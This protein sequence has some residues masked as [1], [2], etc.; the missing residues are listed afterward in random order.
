MSDPVDLFRQSA[1]PPQVKTPPA[2]KGT[3]TAEAFEA[4]FLTQFV[5]EMMKTTGDTAYGGKQQAEM[6]RSFMSE[7]VAQHLVAQG[8]LGLAA[9]VAQMIDAYAQTAPKGEEP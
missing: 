1:L 5:D 4:V 6:W 9:P 7:A 8:G 3:E 2:S